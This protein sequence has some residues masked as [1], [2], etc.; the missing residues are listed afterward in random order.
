[1]LMDLKTKIFLLL[2]ILSLTSSKIMPSWNFDKGGEDWTKSC[3][4]HNQAPLDIAA[5]FQFK[6]NF[7]C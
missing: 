6:G 2:L 3:R 4:N 1:M 7:I 5:P